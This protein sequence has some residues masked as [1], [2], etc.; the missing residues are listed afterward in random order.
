MFN[1]FK[2]RV[3]VTEYNSRAFRYI[4]DEKEVLLSFV[5]VRGVDM[6]ICCM[7]YDADGPVRVLSIEHADK[8]KTVSGCIF[9]FRG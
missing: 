6:L 5:K 4:L 7:Y 2:A 9:G 8:K 1:V 3:K